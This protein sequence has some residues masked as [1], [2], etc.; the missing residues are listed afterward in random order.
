MQVCDDQQKVGSLHMYS[1]YQSCSW[2][3]KYEASIKVNVLGQ[4]SVS[5]LLNTQCFVFVY[6]FMAQVH[7]TMWH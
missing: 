5:I 3:S 7:C 2:G 6:Y 4:V 1:V